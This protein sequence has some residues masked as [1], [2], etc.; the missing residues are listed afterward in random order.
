MLTIN[1]SNVNHA[2]PIALMHLREN[3]V[4]QDSRN[5]PTLEYPE[6]VCTTYQ[7]PEE[8][9][10]FE[11]KRDANPF[12]HLFEALWIIG[13]SRDVA[14]PAL[15]NR[16]LGEYSDDGVTFHAAY[17]YRL[18]QQHGDQVA[19]SIELLRNNVASR[20]VVLQIWDA[21][22]DLGAVSK[23]V[24]CNDLIMLKVRNDRLNMTVCNRSNDLIWGAYGA[25]VVHFSM[26]QE[27]VANKLG[28]G[29]GVYNQV[30]DSLHVYL[31]NPQWEV[32]KCLPVVPYDIY[33]QE[34]V[35]IY[36]L[37]ANNPQ[38]DNDNAMFL[39]DPFGDTKYSTPFFKD[40]VQP[41]AIV[42]QAH[43]SDKSGV[44]AIKHMVRCDWQVA[45]QAWLARRE[46]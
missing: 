42:W 43:K 44:A 22:L 9:V 39:D 13:G 23:D 36:P 29:V 37:G 24:P 46:P 25:N 33:L 31:D 19:K 16:R 11:P 8:R 17:G 5:G 41:M 28:L 30:S 40:I 7:V 32:L 6:P 27:Y 15:F 35:P 10:L 14:F 1:V 20:Q 2:L 3:G 38:W 4:L 18:R 21:E 34:D 12:F 26:L 45:A